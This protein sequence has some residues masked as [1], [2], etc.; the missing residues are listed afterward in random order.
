MKSAITIVLLTLGFT[1]L[2]AGSTLAQTCP[3]S[4]I[5]DG[6][7][8]NCTTL[9]IRSFCTGGS[10]GA[11]I[12][13]G[14]YNLP[15]GTLRTDTSMS[16]SFGGTAVVLVRDDFRVVG[17]A[18]GSPLNF[19]AR[20]SYYI[21]GARQSCASAGIG[22]GDATTLNVGG[23]SNAE[24]SLLMSGELVL[25]LVHVAGDVFRIAARMD[26]GGNIVTSGSGTWRFA[27]LPQGARVESCQGFIQDFPVATLPA[28]WGA[29]KAQYR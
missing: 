13:C 11:G 9:P 1:S 16:G 20:F 14:N 25:P 4:C 23:C 2:L 26:S 22:E 10:H 7:G 5:N 6:L 18:P 8:G 27:G 29:V 21:S 19:T 15:A 17:I 28:S 3:Q 24:T 12:G